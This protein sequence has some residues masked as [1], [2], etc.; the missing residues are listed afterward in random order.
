VTTVETVRQLHLDNANDIAE[1]LS[2]TGDSM[3]LGQVRCKYTVTYECTTAPY[4]TPHTQALDIANKQ[5]VLALRVDKEALLAQLA[6]MQ[7]RIEALGA[8]QQEQAKGGAE[9][10]AEGERQNAE[11]GGEEEEEEAAEAQDVEGGGED[12]GDG[13]DEVA[14]PFLFSHSVVLF[15]CSHMIAP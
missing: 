1:Q 7:G 13:G 10:E 11:G 6:E 15:H 9:Q 4:T 3:T 5:E 8:A 12:V 14:S 2:K